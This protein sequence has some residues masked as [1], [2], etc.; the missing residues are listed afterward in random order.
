MKPPLFRTLALAV[1]IHSSFA[2]SHS[3]FAQSASPTLIPFQGRLTD[4]NGTA[5]STG[6]F[7]VTFNLYDQA[8]GGTSVWTERH[9]KVSVINGMINAF[10]GSVAGIEGVDFTTTKYLGIAVDADD[11]PATP[12][13]E[14]VPRTMI[15]PAFFAKQAENSSQ[16][17][18]AGWDAVLTEVD[19]NSA[20]AVLRSTKIADGAISETKL[21]DGSVT[22]AKIAD[23]AIANDSLAPGAASANL[24]AEGLIA[25]SNS[26]IRVVS[27]VNAVSTAGGETL[28]DVPADS[29]ARI[30]ITYDFT[31]PPGP[32]VGLGGYWDY[33]SVT[34]VNASH[35]T[36]NGFRF[37]HSNVTVGSAGTPPPSGSANTVTQIGNVYCAISGALQPHPISIGGVTHYVTAGTRFDVG[38]STMVTSVVSGTIVSGTVFTS[39]P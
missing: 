27:A 15:I 36:G 13:P 23:G 9:E 19:A 8:I 24:A 28:V 18:G 38:P 25:L 2:I 7:T 35:T 33:F 29:F 12:E 4:Q 20:T 30:T 14:M 31:N 5:Y 11:N 26:P 34:P 37:Y 6:Q 10:L 16:L 32:S 21:A 1:A 3:S 17:N 22:S 39:A